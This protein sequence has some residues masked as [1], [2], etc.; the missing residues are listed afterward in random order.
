MRDA[1]LTG[2]AGGKAISRRRAAAA[3]A[4]SWPQPSTPPSR[5]PQTRSP[6]Q[7]AATIGEAPGRLCLLS[8][9]RLHFR[10]L[11]SA[12]RCL[13]AA[14]AHM[15]LLKTSACGLDR[16]KGAYAFA[17]ATVRCTSI[18][19]EQHMHILCRSNGSVRPS[20][21]GQG[22]V[23]LQSIKW[24]VRRATL[25]R[26]AAVALPMQFCSRFVSMTSPPNCTQFSRQP[27]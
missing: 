1:S 4:A 21:S 20:S 18:V 9:G 15:P 17:G 25:H 10:T 23:T 8:P 26:A 11:S 27:H 7:A 12:G 6:W 14:H 16:D 3:A 5:T 2:L 19:F 13:T 22:D 24:R